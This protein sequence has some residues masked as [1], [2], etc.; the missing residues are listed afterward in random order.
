MKTSNLTLTARYDKL[1]M[2]WYDV[3]ISKLEIILQYFETDT[4]STEW[5]IKNSKQRTI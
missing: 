1:Y 3:D 5:E 2:V 4:K